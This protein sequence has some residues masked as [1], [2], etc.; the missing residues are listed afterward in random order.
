MKILDLYIGKYFIKYFLLVLFILGFMFSFFEF[1][2]Q[3]DDIGRG[4]YQFKDALFFVLLTLPNRMLDLI[5][6]STLLGS[7]IAV[8]LLADNNELLAMHAGGISVWR[9]CGSVLAAAALPMLAVGIL[10]ELIAPPLEQ[11]ALERRLAALTDMD[12]I[13]T[14][15]G[16][17]MRK[18]PFFIHV[19]NVRPNGIP[20]DIDIF[21]WDQ[22]GYLRAFIHAEK[23]DITKDK[24]WI[25]KDV[26][27]KSITDQGI[28][29]Q[30]SL[31]SLSMKSFLST[32]Q[33][34]IQKLPPESLSP[35]D[36]YQ[37]IRML[38]KRGQNA[39]Q[40][41]VVFWKKV[42]LPLS[43]AAMVLVSL[44]FVFGSTRGI[45]AGQRIMTGSIVGVA[46]YFLNEILEHIGLIFRVNPAISTI[47]PITVIFCLAL[48][49]LSRGP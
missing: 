21:E 25:L 2:A 6:G 3:I 35:S 41:E 33:M 13:F 43:M 49:L 46:I 27:K 30:Q 9:I 4:C 24:Q 47:T 34:I 39:D 19:R 5:P 8:G 16:F 11:Y 14:K 18:E 10:A 17:W 36:L 45:T 37:Y 23:A 1:V 22:E 31:E 7:I 12:I 26:E 29:T 40:Y 42:L 15:Q 32:N 28:I 20:A 44:S 48:W 38:R